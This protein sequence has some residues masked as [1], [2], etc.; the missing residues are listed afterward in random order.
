MK[1]LFISVY[2]QDYKKEMP[3][4]LKKYALTGNTYIN[5][6]RRKYGLV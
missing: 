6:K 5:K 2:D 1:S 4:A 3:I